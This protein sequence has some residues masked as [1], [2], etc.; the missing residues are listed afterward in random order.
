MEFAAVVLR[1]SVGLAEAAE[2]RHVE[3]RQNRL[4]EPPMAEHLN[5]RC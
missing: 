4:K 3:E 1:L 2:L 5:E